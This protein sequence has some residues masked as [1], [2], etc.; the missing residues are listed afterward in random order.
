MKKLLFLLLLIPFLGTSQGT[1]TAPVGYNTGA[2]TAA[3]SGVGTRW[4]FDLLTGKKY[5][6]NPDAVAWDE[7]AAGIDQVSGCASPAYTPGYN[8][9]NFAVNSCSTPELY[10]YYSSAWHCLNCGGGSTGPQGPPGPS[11]PTG[12][13]GPQGPIGLT[14]PAGATG[15]TGS[16]GPI[17]LT[18]DTGATG[19]QGPIGLTGP[20]GAA[21]ATGPQGPIGLTGP[22]G[23]TGATGPQGLTGD[24]GATGPQGPIGL[25]GPAGP[26]G[27]AG[28]SGSYTAGSGITI[29]G[30][31]PD[32]TISADDNSP[33]NELQTLSID[34]NDLTLSDG[35]GTVTLPGG[36]GSSVS[37]D[38]YRLP[39]SYQ[40][41]PAVGLN[42]NESVSNYGFASI[43][44]E[45]YK[46]STTAYGSA[47]TDYGGWLANGVSGDSVA[48]SAPF[49]VVIGD[50]QA[51]GHPG[52][53]GRLHPAGAS[54][55]GATYQDEYG[56]L[57]YTLRQLTR[58]RWFNHGISIQTSTQ[59]WA[60]WGRDV[61]GQTVN[62]G[63]GRGSKTLQ[64]K[65]MG[66]VVVV[67]INDFYGTPVSVAVTTANLENMAKSA[68][69]N[70]IQCV[71]LNCPGDEI[72]SQ[73]QIKRVD[74]LNTYFASG[75]LQAFGASVVDYNRWWRDAD[76]DDN[77][78]GQSLITD[79][80]HPSVIG[81][82]SLARYI[83]RSAKLPVLD[84]VTIYTGLSPAGFSGYSRPTA[85]TI[86][87]A[88]YALS[89]ETSTVPFT[90][91]MA[92]DS[93]WIKVVSSTN[94][95]GTSYSGFS[96]IVWH[97]KNDTSG[98]FTRRYDQYENYQGANSTTWSRS[99]ATLSPATISD[100]VA[101]G[102]TANPLGSWLN[103]KSPLN[104]GN[105]VFSVAGSSNNA[106]FTVLDNS[107]VVV[108]AGS[109]GAYQFAVNGSSYFQNTTGTQYNFFSG[110]TWEWYGGTPTWKMQSTVINTGG[111]GYTDFNM[112]FDG[113]ELLYKPRSTAAG[114]DVYVRTMNKVR[115]WG[116]SIGLA[117]KN[118]GI[119][120][121]V[122]N[123]SSVLDISSTTG[124]LLPP[125]MTTAQR[126][127]ISSPA[128]G[129][130]LYCTDC[131]ATDSSTGVQQVWNGSTWKNAW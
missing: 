8:Q 103:V 65:P 24:T 97:V 37:A 87:G 7:D 75:A 119:G 18:G 113:A 114:A 42:A 52:K 27:P 71:F 95:S 56:T 1:F 118:V 6:W 58:M 99:S 92:W 120:I 36:D 63:D 5:T 40:K 80:I 131:T 126:N 94:I 107:R 61:L 121:E 76:Y 53:H 82:D 85:I 32:I 77:S 31:A 102:T 57:S 30:A 116:F 111:T 84:S 3:P 51:E 59:V 4:R 62:V 54:S 106:I 64:R 96:H 125:R 17:G 115:D 105:Y 72:I 50:S 29:T 45:K 86:Q 41:I 21:G 25:T 89:G 9:S 79:D 101:I 78:H 55:F 16:Q 15:A 23:A 66:V 20:T 110:S 123:A 12:A 73:L 33:T 112:T 74:S 68:R 39:A 10:Q 70:G 90:T 100:K 81:Y 98:V 128:T 28:T 109:L 122:P 91:P 46:F 129:L 117:T 67:G 2:P 104:T 35:G 83:F 13:T 44:A 22:A 124:G 60:R 93:V 127:A 88:S 11:G 108:N 38:N 48:V 47:S 43:N 34:G 14:G 26:Q 69:D 19:P 130:T 49:W